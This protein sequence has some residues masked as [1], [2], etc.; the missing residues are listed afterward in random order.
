[1]PVVANDNGADVEEASPVLVS[2]TG[3]P[4][5]RA[6]TFRLTLDPNRS[7]HRALLFHAG[8]ARLAFKHHLGRVKT[9]LGQREA[10]ASYGIPTAPKAAGPEPVPRVRGRA[11]F[12]R[13]RVLHAHQGVKAVQHAQAR[14]KLAGQT[15]SRTKTGS[16]GRTTR[17]HDAWAGVHARV[18]R[19]RGDLLHRVTTGAGPRLPLGHNRGPQ[20][21]RDAHQPP[22][23][24][25][26]LGCRVRG[27]PPPADLQDGLV[28]DRDVNA[29]INLAR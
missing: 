25:C 22:A 17:Q 13:G 14:L 18:T 28:I 11:R 16:T 3:V 7:Q 29:A 9:N 21:G 24:P 10:E 5:S 12:E 26:H 4:L 6:T 8:A 23:R 2:H 20:H 27:A 1:V 19:L 15:H